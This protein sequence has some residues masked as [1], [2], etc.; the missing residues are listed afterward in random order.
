MLVAF[1]SL[2]VFT[3]NLPIGHHTSEKYITQ[4][5]RQA[6]HL[7]SFIIQDNDGYIFRYKR[8]NENWVICEYPT[9]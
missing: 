5:S 9:P 6:P 4:V 8:V 1:V 2:R 7:K 3:L